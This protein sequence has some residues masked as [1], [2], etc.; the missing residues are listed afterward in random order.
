MRKVVLIIIDVILMNFAM[1]F[2]L[3]SPYA[4]EWDPLL[5]SVDADK[6][7]VLSLFWV[8]LT[9]ILIGVVFWKYKKKVYIFQSAKGVSYIFYF[10]FLGY[11]ICKVIWLA[12]I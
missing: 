1:L 12:L 9:I 7:L 3:I 6:L 2:S 4:Y 8:V 11:S 5:R 10:A